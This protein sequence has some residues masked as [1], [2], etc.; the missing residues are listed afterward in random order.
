[1]LDLFTRLVRDFGS[2]DAE[3]RADLRLMSQIPGVISVQDLAPRQMSRI[4]GVVS[5]VTQ[6]C[7]GDSPRLHITVA[8]GTGE[9]H[10]QFLGRREISGIRPGALIVLEGRFCSHDGALKAH[11]PVYE[12]IQTRD[13][14]E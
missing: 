7:S 11:N 8:D 10:A 5:A 9:V 12:L 14:H 13:D 1:M 6:S 2:R 3:A 4:A